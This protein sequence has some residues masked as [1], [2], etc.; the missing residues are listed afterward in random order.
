MCGIAGILRL[1]PPGEA[2]R[3]AL[4]RTP[5]DAIPEAWLDVVDQSVR[6]R[7]PDG[8]G[9]FRDRAVRADGTV[10]DVALVHRRL[11]IID[12]GG[13]AQPMVSQRAPSGTSRTEQADR[14]GLGFR[15]F[16]FHGKPDASV[17]YQQLPD[18]S[19]TL[20]VVF[21]GCIYNH[22][23][24]RRELEAAGRRFATD[25]SDTEVLLHGWREWGGE[26]FDRLRGMFALSIWDRAAG[27]LVV[28]RD[29][30]GEKPLYTL[31]FGAH[32]D[33]V[34]GCCSTLAGPQRLIA[35][36]GNSQTSGVSEGLD[37][38]I[39]FGYDSLTPG[40][41]TSSL[42]AS[43]W[44]V[45]GDSSDQWRGHSTEYART[46]GEWPARTGRI[47]A[48]QALR[49]IERSVS[50]RLD[51]DVPLGC[52]L[53]GGVDSSLI[54][55]L[56][57]QRV[58]KLSTFTVRMPAAGYDETPFA[59]TVAAHIGASHTTL[60]CRPDPAADLVGL[61]EQLGLPFGDSSL[62][63]THWI[64]EAA[65]QHVKVCLTGDGG[66]EM[67]VGYE[68]H[69]GA[70]VLADR[71]GLLRRFPSSLLKLNHPKSRSSKLARLVDAARG[72]GYLDLVSIFPSRMLRS[73]LGRAER[74][75]HPIQRF[76]TTTNAVL[77]D[78]LVHLPNDLMRK[79]D[80]GSMAAALE[81]RAPFL[82]H[83]LAE[84]CLG[85][86]LDD[87]VPRGRRKG[88]L[89]AAARRHLPAP[90][91]DRPKMGFAIPIGG[92]FRTDYGGLRTLLLDHMNSAEPFGPPSLGIVLNM[93]FV[94]QMLDEHLGTGKSGLVTRDHSQ[95]LYMLLVLSVW[96]RWLGG[97]STRPA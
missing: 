31:G 37:E 97:L 75:R 38:W 9:R 20:A 72:D 83:D 90:I 71:A 16:V 94:R 54:A 14:P 79:S 44:G 42:P 47:T 45:F 23:E 84:L 85:A 2:A 33:T 30:F 66:D 51:A 70:Q 39:R 89:R 22:R 36:Y 53:S 7:G 58:E 76:G 92:W 34:W 52:F 82:D 5:F 56:A 91:V 3:A 86:T 50:E 15:P 10:V 81:L 64:S 40:V 24:L 6:H 61:I 48:E 43:H 21:N 77:Y 8:Q 46:K 18:V 29:Q 69:F 96:A 32:F 59:E 28:A 41:G 17:H 27:N 65:R 55:A 62:L 74:P 19:D 57:A 13:G 73:L 1:T 63:P 95:R 78:A 25:H 4:E 68:R 93:A 26:L 80:T 49:E 87:L 11:S 60:D 35:R 67:F 88:L 12:H